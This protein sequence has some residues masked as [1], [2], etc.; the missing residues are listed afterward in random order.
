MFNMSL[1]LHCKN[2]LVVLTTEWLPWLQ[3]LF[4]Y[5]RL[6]VYN[7]QRGSFLVVS[8]S[9][10]Y[11]R[12]RKRGGNN[13]ETAGLI[14]LASSTK[15]NHATKVTTLFLQC[16]SGDIS[17]VTDYMLR[18]TRSSD[19]TFPYCK[20][21]KNSSPGKHGMKLANAFIFCSFNIMAVPLLQWGTRVFN[22]FLLYT[23]AACYSGS[24][25]FLFHPKSGSFVCQDMI[26]TH[27]LKWKKSTVYQWVA[28]TPLS[29]THTHDSSH[30]H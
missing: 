2:S 26:H 27:M 13:K 17:C 7:N 20:P 19:S 1:C 5:Q 12:M 21:W 28:V 10:P 14:Q 9:F 8:S 16:R 6:V 4:C 29:F 15:I 23:L 3:G 18:F 30:G 24:S 22:L 25:T 11:F